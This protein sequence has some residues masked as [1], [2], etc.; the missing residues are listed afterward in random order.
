MTGEIERLLELQAKDQE[1]V[2]LAAQIKH[3]N[4]QRAHLEKKRTEEIARVDDVRHALE[5]LERESRQRNLEV[6]DLDMQIHTYQKRL[7]EGIISFKEMEALREKIA[8]QRARMNTMEDE[9]L[10]LMERIVEEK[11]SLARA[12]EE[13]TA[14]LA[15]LDAAKRDLAAR[16]SEVE[17]ALSAAKA[18]REEIAGRISPSLLSRYENLRRSFPDPVVPIKNGVCS[19]CKLRVSEHTIERARNTDEIV[20]CENCS[21]ILYIR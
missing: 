7:D 18:A 16:I 5:A 6:D 9:A 1:G 21:R 10:M 20:T 8:N 2:T 3:L 17:Q 15:E 19:G 12:E 11:K 4:D 14:R 13:L